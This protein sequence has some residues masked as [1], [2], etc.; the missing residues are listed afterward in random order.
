MSSGNLSSP[1]GIRMPP[2]LIALTFGVFVF[3]ADGAVLAGMLPELSRDLGVPV[4][5]AGQLVTAFFLASAFSAPGLGLVG[6]SIR[7]RDALMGGLGAFLLGNILT[8]SAQGLVVALVGRAITGIGSALFIV[9]AFAAAASLS[10]AANR[11]R[12]LG[13]L[14]IGTT[15]ALV[16]AV[17]LGAWW[18]TVSSWRWFMALLVGLAVVCSIAVIITMPRGGEV[19]RIGLRQRIQPVHDRGV[20]WLLVS[21]VSTRVAYYAPYTFAGVLF[22]DVSHQAP[23]W[24]ALLLLAL[25]LSAIPGSLLGGYWADRFGTRPVLIGSI[26]VFAINLAIL[27]SS[28]LTMAGSLVAVV[29]WGFAGWMIGIPQ[30]HALIAFAPESPSIVLGLSNS[31]ASLGTAIGGA[32]G[33]GA[34]VLGGTVWIGP[35]ASAFALIA[36]A[37]ALASKGARNVA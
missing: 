32:V 34:L 18:V 10:E 2:A 3:T 8:C 4:S 6:A 7:T 22:M 33:G 31:S 37:S 23:G 12:R 14:Q 35:V 25:G 21:T 9:N 29:V 16:A 28:S 24:L 30:V 15:A 20:V 13:L 27:P 26:V 5:A 1:A 11:G 17:P 19:P 36:L